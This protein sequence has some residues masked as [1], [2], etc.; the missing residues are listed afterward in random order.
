MVFYNFSTFIGKKGIY[1]EDLFI[2]EEHRGEGYGEQILRYLAQKA[3]DEN[4]ER[5]EWIVH[6]SNKPSIEFYKKLGAE[7]MDE[8]TVQCVSGYNLHKL[9]TDVD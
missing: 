7:A 4:C 3:L 8:W 1:L 2:Q 5:F 6:N 9:A